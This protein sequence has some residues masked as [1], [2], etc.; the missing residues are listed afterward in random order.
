MENDIK[1]YER[2]QKEYIN[3]K[4][5]LDKEVADVRSKYITLENQLD[6]EIKKNLY[7][8]NQKSEYEIMQSNKVN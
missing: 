5:I 4:N 1:E 3:Q 6:E 8:Q 7:L 2:S